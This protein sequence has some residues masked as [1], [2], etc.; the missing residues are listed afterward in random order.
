MTGQARF[1]YAP[2]LAILAALAL[3]P[4]EG[5]ARSPIRSKV[6]TAIDG[7]A[8]G[9][10]YPDCPTDSQG[11]RDV[12]V[13]VRALTQPNSKNEVFVELVRNYRDKDMRFIKVVL[14]ANNPAQAGEI[15]LA[16]GELVRMS[17]Y[18]APC[19]GWGVFRGNPDTPRD[20]RSDEIIKSYQSMTETWLETGACEKLGEYRVIVDE[21]GTVQ[22]PDA[23]LAAQI[24]SG[25]RATPPIGGPVEL[26]VNGKNDGPSR[27]TGSAKFSR[28][29]IWDELTNPEYFKVNSY[30][31][32]FL[33]LKLGQESPSYKSEAVRF[34]C[35]GYGLAE[36]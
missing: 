13:L 35:E 17:I 20:D 31:E 2:A 11:H 16:S 14:P 32:S 21:L 22:S 26:T 24:P 23:C 9:V 33:R 36:A 27:I 3:M 29:W 6:E 19:Q 18:V 15:Y 25:F 10:E 4:A 30:E 12:E 28:S 5:D 1:T 8:P 7:G 34:L